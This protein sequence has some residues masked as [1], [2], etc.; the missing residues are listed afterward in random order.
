MR[1]LINKNQTQDVRTYYSDKN[2]AV[3]VHKEG[4]CFSDDKEM[5]S[6]VEYFIK[7]LNFE[8]VKEVSETK[9]KG[10]K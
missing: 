6:T 5:D 7:N 8:L 4:I 9:S 1:K 3:I 10:K 2:E